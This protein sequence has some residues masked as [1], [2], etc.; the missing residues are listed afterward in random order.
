MLFQKKQHTNV[1]I[2]FNI[3]ISS[4]IN[5]FLL[6]ISCYSNDILLL[7]YCF[8]IFSEERSGY[9]YIPSRFAIYIM[10]RILNPLAAFAKAIL[11][12]VLRRIVG[13]VVVYTS[14]TSSL[15]L[16]GPQTELVDKSGRMKKDM[17]CQPSLSLT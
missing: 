2:I 3:A 5:R 6:F 4:G 7:L 13:A 9:I 10:E 1:M 11:F 16:G 14:T 8:N 15:K 17:F 12:P